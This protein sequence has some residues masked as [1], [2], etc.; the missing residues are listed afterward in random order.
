MCSTLEDKP[1]VTTPRMLLAPLPNN[2]GAISSPN[3]RPLP[4]SSS[5]WM[6]T[7]RPPRTVHRAYC[8]ARSQLIALAR[9][10]HGKQRGRVASTSSARGRQGQWLG[11]WGRHRRRGVGGR[12]QQRARGRHMRL[13][14]SSSRQST[15]GEKCNGHGEQRERS[16]PRLPRGGR[17]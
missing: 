14:L 2:S 10:R 11:G 13:V 6:T 1:H 15:A 4:L 7:K 5:S 16:P 12:D 9:Q 17:Q 8:F 3:L